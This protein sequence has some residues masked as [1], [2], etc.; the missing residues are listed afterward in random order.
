MNNSYAI[1]VS[2]LDANARSSFINKTYNHLLGAIAAFTLIE[3]ILFKTGIAYSMAEVMLSGHWLII[4]GAF[5]VVSWIATNF[6]QSAGS[7]SSQYMGLGLYVIA[8]AIIFVPLL[9]MADLY[10]PG[11]IASAAVV[12]LA[13]FG[14]LTLIAFFTR[15]DFSFLGSILKWCGIMALVLIVASF[16]FYR[17]PHIRK[18]FFCTS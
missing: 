17:N 16:G 7:K 9:V 3:V 1:P 13:G 4:L 2:Q 10:A 14:G 6:A 15:K 8:E 11:T 5:M 18:L 12:T